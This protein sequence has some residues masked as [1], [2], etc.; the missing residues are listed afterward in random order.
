MSNLQYTNLIEDFCADCGMDPAL[1]MHGDPIE[2]D[3]VN[4][5]LVFSESVDPNLLFIYCVCGE[6]EAGKELEIYRG[7]LEANM[8][9]YNGAGPIYTLCPLTGRVILVGHCRL[10]QLGVEELKGI[11]M[12]A[13][14][15]AKA[16]QAECLTFATQ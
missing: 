2:I 12:T 1:L 16:W 4:F 10:D 9:L 7:L 8:H 11:L 14:T 5:S 15:Q 6:I 3:G 13:I